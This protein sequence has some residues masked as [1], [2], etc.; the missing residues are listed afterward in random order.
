MML[1]VLYSLANT[2]LTG[3]WGGDM[4]GITALTNV[5]KDTQITD[6]K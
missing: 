2:Y 4:S 6:L 5:L 1:V 3:R